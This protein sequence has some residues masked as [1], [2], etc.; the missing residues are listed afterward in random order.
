VV[1]AYEHHVKVR[2]TLALLRARLRERL[3]DVYAQVLGIEP[4]RVG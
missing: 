2:Q 1:E 3:T 4:P